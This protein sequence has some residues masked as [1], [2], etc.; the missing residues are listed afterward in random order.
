MNWKLQ[1]G[2]T[3]HN[4]EQWFIRSGS[5]F[6]RNNYPF[7]R[8]WMFD[9]KRIIDEPSIIVDAGAHI[10]SVS[11]ELNQSFPKAV[12]Y[13]FEPVTETFE[14][15][16]ANVAGKTNI[17]PVKMALGANDEKIQLLLSGENS[18][19]SLKVT[20]VNS[21]IK[22]TEEINITTLQGYLQQQGIDHIDI[23]K[24]DVEG[25]EFEVL[26][27]CA[28]LLNTGIKCIYLEV[29]Y[30]RQSTKVHFSDVETFMENHDFE[31]CGIYET[32]RHMFDK[33][34]LWYS[35]NLYV[36]KNLLES[37]Y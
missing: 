30:I 36:K 16:K 29:G 32:R 24:I 25:F 27:G 2:Q 10:G 12:V 31:L 33:R 26:E 8:D 20:E 7:G 28:G 6:A 17:H 5:K 1:I 9:V 15:L 21:G 13:A 18:I 37:K 14:M 4:L 22:G 19:N 23:L 35:N 34:R 11:L 3:V